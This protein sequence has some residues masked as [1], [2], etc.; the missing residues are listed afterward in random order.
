MGRVFISCLW[1][2]KIWVKEPLPIL[3]NILPEILSHILPLMSGRDRGYRL[4]GAGLLRLS[5]GGKIDW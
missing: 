5:V 4:G 3:F 1:V 2:L